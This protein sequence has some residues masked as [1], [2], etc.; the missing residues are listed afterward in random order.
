[1]LDE[2]SRDS[3]LLEKND[4]IQRFKLHTTSIILDLKFTLD[5]YP[6]TVLFRHKRGNARAV[7]TAV[8]ERRVRHRRRRQ[9]D[10]IIFRLAYRAE[11]G[12][13][14]A[15]RADRPSLP[16]RRVLLE[17]WTRLVVSRR[18]G[19]CRLFVANRLNS[20]SPADDCLCRIVMSCGGHDKTSKTWAAKFTDAS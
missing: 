11:I 20:N 9:R 12:N 2:T 15:Y 3:F 18:N 10:N 4:N 17:Q 5:R 13:G 1:M 7:T 6:E 19:P 14:R 8:G 16:I